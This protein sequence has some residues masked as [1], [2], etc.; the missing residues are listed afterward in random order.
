MVANGC[1]G[2]GWD[3]GTDARGVA[4]GRGGGVLDDGGVGDERV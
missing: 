4:D 2:C 1:V 3:D